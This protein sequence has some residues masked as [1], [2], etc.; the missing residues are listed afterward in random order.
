MASSESGVSDH[1]DPRFVG[2][3]RNKRREKTSEDVE[4]VSNENEAFNPE[5]IDSC[6]AGERPKEIE[7]QVIDAIAEDIE[8]EIVTSAS[9]GLLTAGPIPNASEFSAYPKFAQ[10]KIIEW[11]DR[12][13]KATCDDESNRQNQLVDAE[14]SRSRC[15]QWLSFVVD[16]ALIA[17]PLIAYRF[18]GDPNVFWIYSVLGANIIGNVAIT[19]NGNNKERKDK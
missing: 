1:D 10:D 16:I 5:E 4:A 2:D 17:A 13:I 14:I 7:R 9:V 12:E 6:G 8:D 19:I 18:F 15:N 11:H 3:S